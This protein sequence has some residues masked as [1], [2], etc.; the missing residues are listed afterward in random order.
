MNFRRDKKFNQNV[1]DIQFIEIFERRRTFRAIYTLP[2]NTLVAILEDGGSEVFLVENQLTHE[3]RECRKDDILFT[4]VG[5]PVLYTSFES[6]R[7]ISLHFN[8][9]RYLGMDVYNGC[10]DWVVK[11]DPS[12]AQKIESAFRTE[13]P[14]KSLTE[15]R[16]CCLDFCTH[17]WPKSD[18]VDSAE[19]TKM[20]PVIDWINAHANARTSI[21]DL[22][23]R[24]S[25]SPV[26]FSRKFK[27]LF[28]ESPKKYLEKIL[29]NRAFS[30]LS[31]SNCKV[32]DAADAL[33]FSSEYYFSNF[34]KRM[35]GISPLE[36][37]KQLQQTEKQIDRE[38][39]ITKSGS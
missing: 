31:N 28:R 10:K 23:D 18:S 16:V 39:E 38:T 6:C 30:L 29:M 36:Y 8:L 12:L 22:A 21:D 19:L 11:H 33:G 24:I 35:L 20:Y 2:C 4:P 32:K 5:L 13:D 17:H 15:L 3:A 1:G 7:F 9:Y 37:K 26:V 25:L 27:A 14:L 34:F